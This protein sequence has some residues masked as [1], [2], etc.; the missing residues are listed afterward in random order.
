MGST[1]SCHCTHSIAISSAL[2]AFMSVGPLGSLV[3]SPSLPWH[4]FSL[5]LSWMVC[6]IS[7]LFKI[8][9]PGSLSSL[10]ILCWKSS[11][12]NPNWSESSVKLSLWVFP[13]LSCR[14]SYLKSYSKIFF[15]FVWKLAQG[16][17]HLLPLCKILSSQFSLW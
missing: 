17:K 11:V 14:M 8:W 6:I 4:C 16:S 2:N 1:E 15:F 12:L 7:S 13:S 3:S 10:S 5:F 9:K